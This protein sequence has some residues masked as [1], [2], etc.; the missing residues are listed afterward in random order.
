MARRSLKPQAASCRHPRISSCR[1]AY[2]ELGPL[3]RRDL[4]AQVAGLTGVREHGGEEEGRRGG[5]IAHCA[6]GPRRRAQGIACIYL[7]MANGTAWGACPAVRCALCSRRY[8]WSTVQQCHS[9]S[10]SN[11]APPAAI[12]RRCPRRPQRSAAAVRRHFFFFFFLFLNLPF[13]CISS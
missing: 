10:C 13:P 4:W 12:P 3:M 1:T 9:C 11:K 5:I 8:T 7:P 2:G 6:A